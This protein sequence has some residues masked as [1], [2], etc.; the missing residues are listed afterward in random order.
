MGAIAVLLLAAC[1]PV[2]P[3]TGGL[4]SPTPSSAPS[5]VPSPSPTATQIPDPPPYRGAIVAVYAA[6][7]NNGIAIHVL[8]SSRG[9]LADHL[10][11][12]SG[13]GIEL[14]DAQA[15]RLLVIDTGPD[16][17]RDMLE[18][19]DLLDG[20]RH[21]I[22]DLRPLQLAAQ[23]P[24]S[25]VLSPDATQAAVGVAHKLIVYTLATA[26]SRE[27][28]SDSS[29]G[30]WIEPVRWTAS[31]IIASEVPYEGP[32]SDVI[33]V[34]ASTGAMTVVFTPT[35]IFA[36]SPD[37]HIVAVA[38][39]T[40]LGDGQGERFPWFNTLTEQVGGGPPTQLFQE[41]SRNFQPLD[42]DN[43][44]RVLFNSAAA[45]TTPTAPDM[46]IYLVAAARASRQLPTTFYGEWIAAAFVDSST[47]LVSR[48]IGG[49][50]TTQTEAELDLMHLCPDTSSG[51]QVTMV[52]V[53]STA[54]PYPTEIGVIHVLGSIA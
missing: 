19:L 35:P 53:S 47:A 24:V 21:A 31:G 25:G 9:A 42:V 45:S 39:N 38:T 23:G 27:L 54:G 12:P 29:N 5:A 18:T 17:S 44:G 40:D 34:D 10:I 49:S 52:K 2:K 14:L 26:G 50:L 20:A 4:T 28:T 1:T 15:T 8:T 7:V 3:P 11:A 48:V 32:A 46:G 13:Q 36:L 6:L 16:H 43:S 33:H 30:R 37:G 41:K 51:C 22:A